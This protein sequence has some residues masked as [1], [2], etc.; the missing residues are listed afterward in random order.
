[1]AFGGNAKSVQSRRNPSFLRLWCG[2]EWS[3]AH[4]EVKRA[5]RLRWGLRVG[6][7]RDRGSCRLLALHHA[8]RSHRSGCATFRRGSFR[9][10]IP[11]T[12]ITTMAPTCPRWSSASARSRRCSSPKASSIPRR[13]MPS[14]RPTRPRS[15]R[16]TAR[17]SSPTPGAI[18]PSRRACSRTGPRPSASSAMAGAAASISP[19]SRTR[20]DAHNLVVCTLCSCYP[21]PV[22]GLPPV[23]YKSAPYRSRAVIDPRGVLAEFG[24]HLPADDRNPRLGFDAEMRYLVLPMRP[25]GTEGWSEER[26]AALVTRDSHDRHRPAAVARGGAMN[27]AQDV[28]G[29]TS[30][31]PV[32]ARAERAGVPR[33]AS[34]RACLRNV[35]RDRCAG[36]VDRRC[37]PL[38]AGIAAA[39]LLLHATYYE[40]WLAALEKL[41]AEKHLGRSRRNRRRPELHEFAGHAAAG[42]SRPTRSRRRCTSG[43]PSERPAA[44]SRA[45]RSAIACARRISI[46]RRTR[47]CRAMRAARSASIEK[48]AAISCFRHERAWPA[49][50]TRNGATMCAFRAREL[51]G[52]DA[53]PHDQ[54]LDRRVRAVSG[55]CLMRTS[56]G[57]CRALAAR[58]GR[59]G[60]PRAVGGAGLRACRASAGARPV[61]L[62]GMGAS[63]RRGNRGRTTERRSRSRRHL[64]PALA[65]RIGAPRR[66]ERRGE[67]GRFGRQRKHAWDRAAKATPHGQPIVLGE[68]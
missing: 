33:R 42:A 12:I 13:S 32:D 53:D 45:S 37:Q 38:C 19:S 4:Y 35:H 5:S 67:S 47:A 60:F 57:D 14:S 18:R 48:C 50:K 34:S 63:A 68:I 10:I 52:E 24:V 51:W 41:L 29:M 31:G 16:A 66:R 62:G 23:W 64:L 30:F 7:A 40:I 54:R 43:W 15:G 6:S 59:S 22:L 21:W 28:G 58:C 55:A 46:R 65:A 49:A 27:G 61:H 1:M 9:M 56:L 25:A 17:M 8:R 39:A 2:R 20:P 3:D 44:I 11:A 36:P 26:L